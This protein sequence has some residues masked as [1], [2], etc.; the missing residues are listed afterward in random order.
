[1]AAGGGREAGTPAWMEKSLDCVHCGLCLLQCPTYQ[2]F[3]VEPD[4]P[5]GRIYLARALA[6]G[7]TSPSRVLKEPLEHCLDCRACESVCPSGVGYHLVLEGA[8]EALAGE[9][10]ARFKERLKLFFLDAVLTRPRVLRLAF[11]LLALWERSGLRKLTR[12][13]LFGGLKRMEAL[14]P[15]IPPKKERRL[16]P[17][18]SLPRGRPRGRAALF[19]GCVMTELF[20]R[21]HFDALRLLLLH[22]VE[23]L[24]PPRQFCCGALSLHAGSRERALELARLNLEAFPKDV[25]WIVFDSAGCGAMLKEYGRLFEGTAL[26]A[27]AKAFSAK[28]RDITEVLVEL[29][30]EVPKGRVDLKVVYDDPCHLCHAQGIRRQPREILR[31]VPGLELVES[32]EPERC[33]GAAGIYNLVQPE[34]SERLLD[35]KVEEVRATGAD[36]VSTGNPGCM[37]QIRYGLAT[38]EGKPMEVFHPVEILARAFEEDG[39]AGGTGTS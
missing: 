21:V 25:D 3:K 5:R 6:E 22:G 18:R 12:L 9:V 1:M 8:R 23:V 37:L 2:L 26:E 20:G 36:A 17:P 35:K 13:I 10:P 31:A 7:K 14:L 30:L 38:R 32:A 11:D 28:A 29:G 16:P 24:V 4:S 39:A 15:P 34:I 33:C 19:T 27:E